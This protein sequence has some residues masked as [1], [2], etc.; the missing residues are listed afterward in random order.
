MLYREIIAVCSQIT[1]NVN[2]LCGQDIAWCGTSSPT[3][4]LAS[5]PAGSSETVATEAR[6]LVDTCQG[7]RTENNRRLIVR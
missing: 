6:Q 1:Q 7:A 3:V 5:W 2:T 4:L